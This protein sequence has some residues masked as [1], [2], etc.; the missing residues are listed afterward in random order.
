[1]SGWSTGGMKAGPSHRWTKP[2]RSAATSRS[3]SGV[4]FTRWACRVST[5]TCTLGRS[6]RSIQ[7]R[8]SVRPGMFEKGTNSRLSFMPYL[9]AR[10]H[11]FSNC[12][13]EKSRSALH[14][15]AIAYFAPSS[16]PR[17]N[18]FS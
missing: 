2:N 15:L 12:T 13:R 5:S 17:A 10:S 9:S 1:M 18:S 6:I 7:A 16:A 11:I 14:T 3:C 4:T 8:A